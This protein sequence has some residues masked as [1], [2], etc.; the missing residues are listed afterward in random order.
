MRVLRQHNSPLKYNTIIN[1]YNYNN[2]NEKPDGNFWNPGG[3]SFE[4]IPRGSLWISPGGG[5]DG[6]EGL[7][8]KD[9]NDNPVYIDP[10]GSG[11]GA[12]STAGAFDASFSSV[13]PFIIQ[14]AIT[15]SS[16]KSGGVNMKLDGLEKD[17]PTTGVDFNNLL[18]ITRGNLAICGISGE[19][20]DSLIKLS[21]SQ[22]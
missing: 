16:N 11:G 17:T 14:K 8:F 22:S 6:T 15:S 20:L 18:T 9:S 13:P 10:T 19:K 5:T 3:N 21:I 12:S 1:F 2:G 7:Y 4:N